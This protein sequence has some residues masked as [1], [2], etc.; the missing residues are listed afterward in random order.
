MHEEDNT[1]VIINR[2]NIREARGTYWL[3]SQEQYISDIEEFEI[4]AALKNNLTPIIDATNLSDK[5][6]AKWSKV[7]N[8]CNAKLEIIK[9]PYISFKEALKRDTERGLNGGRAVGEKVLTK[10]YRQ[11][12]L[13]EYISEMCT[14]KCLSSEVD[15][16]KIPAV[17][18]D[19]DLTLMYRNGRDIYDYKSA[20]NDTIDP[21]A[22][23]LI[24]KL[25][26][27][28]VQVII[29]TG[30]DFTE[31]SLNAI[32]ESMKIQPNEKFNKKVYP[33]MVFGRKVSDKRKSVEVK[34]ENLKVI[35]SM[36]YDI[37]AAFDDSIECVQMY[38]ENGIFACK[39][40]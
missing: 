26:E 24:E 22:K 8:E 6:M 27:S 13:D 2:D 1:K 11:Y 7:A 10:F 12:Y 39:V 33:Y 15:I 38:R 32:Y 21:K 36:N 14:D 9:M 16:N 3:P 17:I 40:N 25:N 20:K 23:F 29:S 37:I 31:D 34:Y 5:T 19:L 35:Q 30:R 28:G 4:K 18:F